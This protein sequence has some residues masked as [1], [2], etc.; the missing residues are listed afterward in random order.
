MTGIDI[1]HQRRYPFQFVQSDALEYLAK[2]GHEYDFIHAS[3]VCKRY[4]KMQRIVKTA[5]NHPDYIGALRQLLKLIEK[6]YVIENVEGAPLV[7]A[8][9]LCGSQFPNLRVYRHRFFESNLPLRVPVHISHRDNVPP[10]GQGVSKKGFF[11]LT[12]GGIRG[13]TQ[14]ERFQGMGIDW[15]TNVEL[16]EAVPP[17][18]TEYIGRQVIEHITGRKSVYSQLP[19]VEQLRLFV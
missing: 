18:F 7:E 2:H 3:P 6:P 15:M 12:S 13:I 10:A 1:V 5:D 19:I 4:S 11:S 9:M 14:A 8:V 17:V 16:N